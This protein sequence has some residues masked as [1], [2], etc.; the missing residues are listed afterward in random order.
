MIQPKKAPAEAGAFF[1]SLLVNS[2]GGPIQPPKDICPFHTLL[3]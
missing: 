2:D 1:V 3:F